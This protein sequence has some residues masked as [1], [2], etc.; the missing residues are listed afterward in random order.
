M[1][2]LFTLIPALLALAAQA[3]TP[4]ESFT[5]LKRV[6]PPD[7]S[8]GEVACI[9]L[10]ADVY[11]HLNMSMNNIRLHDEAGQETPF[12][13]RRLHLVQSFTREREIQ[14]ETISFK[15]LPDNRFEVIFKR[16]PGQ[17]APDAL[18]IISP[19]RNFEKLVTVQ[20]G[21]D[22]GKWATIAGPEQIYD[23]TRFL[24][25]R[26]DRVKLAP[27]EG[28]YYRLEVSNVNE[29]HESPLVEIITH[30]GRDPE[31]SRTEAS[32]FRRVPFRIDNLALIHIEENVRED[33]PR[34]VSVALPI[35]S[36]AN[37]A[38]GSNTL[39]VAA[40]GRRPVLSL[41]LLSRDRN[42][43]RAISV[44]G[45]MNG[46]GDAWRTVAQ[47]TVRSIE[48]GREKLRDLTIAL[49][50]E[51]RFRDYRLVIHNRDNPALDIEGVTA[52]E[53]VY[54]LLFF[55]KPGR[56]YTLL[57]G[58]T[59]IPGPNYD[60]AAVLGA[61]PVEQMD[62]WRAGEAVKNPDYSPLKTEAAAWKNE[63]GRVIFVVAIVVMCIALLVMIARASRKIDKLIDN[64]GAPPKQE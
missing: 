42:F 1:K 58:G 7:T 5:F 28:P 35:E 40:S 46:D 26:K 11:E 30:S 25:A 45:R 4:I 16:G 54:G 23:Y 64:G 37:D 62:S 63:A 18:R 6:A 60:V 36:L 15:E 20:A 3:A 56:A 9:A 43:S 21:P 8:R 59:N 49:P 27:G 51:Q 17:G 22:G 13:I 48:A 57:Y 55:P 52:E 29:A 14:P 61:T 33:R 50:S 39:V 34:R 44:E 31:R 41:T 19:L 53:S 38:A 24:D 12:C 32:A 10:D 47:G 2:Q